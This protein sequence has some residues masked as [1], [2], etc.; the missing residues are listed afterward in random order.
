MTEQIL[1]EDDGAQMR[2]K[3]VQGLLARVKE[4]QAQ[5]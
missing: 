5:F 4:S 3:K 2:A 1:F